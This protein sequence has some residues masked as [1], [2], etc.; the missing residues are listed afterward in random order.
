MPDRREPGERA[1]EHVA[2]RAAACVSHE[3]DAAR[4]AFACWVVQKPLS[5]ARNGDHLS[6]RRV[7]RT[8]AG[9]L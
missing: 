2:R 5:V 4:I 1:V 8:P 6:R 3:A 9:S 7:G